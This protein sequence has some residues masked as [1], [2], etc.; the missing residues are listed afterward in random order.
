M[1]QMGQQKQHTKE[2]KRDHNF[3][4]QFTQFFPAAHMK[5]MPDTIRNRIAISFRFLFPHFL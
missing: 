1:K 3:K 2:R 4:N 5:P